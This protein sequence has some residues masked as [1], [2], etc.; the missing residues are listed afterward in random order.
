MNKKMR[1]EKEETK[2]KRKT[3]NSSCKEQDFMPCVV[4]FLGY[5]D[6]EAEA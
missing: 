5:D 2:K 4:C 6:D 3:P 1:G